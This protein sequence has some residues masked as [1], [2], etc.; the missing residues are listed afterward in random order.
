MPIIMAIG[1]YRPE[2]QIFMARLGYVRL[3]QN[4]QTNTINK[5]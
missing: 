2:D 1:G 4:K 5:C 3:S